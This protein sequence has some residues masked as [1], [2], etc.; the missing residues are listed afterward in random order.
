M[1]AI[2]ATVS[3]SAVGDVVH[4][5]ER[6]RLLAGA[7]DRQRL[8]TVQ[9]LAQQVGH[10]VRDAGLGLGHLARPVGVERPADSEGQPELVCAAQQ[11]TSPASFDHPYADRGGGQ[12]GRYFS[13][14][15]NC[16]ARSNTML[17]EA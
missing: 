17:D 7:E 8:Q 9:R 2:A 11:Y 1:R 10:S 13:V 6:A 5:R 4:V 14:V 16:S 15:G 3:P 12:S